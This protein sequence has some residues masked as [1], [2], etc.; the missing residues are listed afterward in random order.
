MIQELFTYERLQELQHFADLGR[1]S[2][3]LLHEISNPL[4]AALLNLESTDHKSI[5]VRR[6][7]RDMQLMKRYVEA[8]RLQ[9]HRQSISTVFYVQP[10]LNQLKRVMAPLARKAEVR[11]VVGSLAGCR[12]RGDPVKFQQ[13]MTN[14]VVN[15]ID[16]YYE[17]GVPNQLVSVTL[18]CSEGQLLIQV[19]DQASGIAAEALPKLFDEFYTTKHGAKKGLGIGLA[20]VKRYVTEDFQGTINVNSDARGTRFIVTLPTF[21]K[22]SANSV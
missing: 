15:A 10:Q 8:V 2:A 9:V 14:L 4:T 17:I 12:L 1:M 6:A 3:V 13:I 22:M 5:A 19:T 18:A 16:A 21:P 11:L 20:I 7:R